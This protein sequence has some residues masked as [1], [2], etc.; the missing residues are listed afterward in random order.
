MESQH[1]AGIQTLAVVEE[2][3][4]GRALLSYSPSPHTH[5]HKLILMIIHYKKTALSSQFTLN[6]QLDFAINDHGKDTSR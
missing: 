1:V 3:L 2:L 4:E 5:T 6:R